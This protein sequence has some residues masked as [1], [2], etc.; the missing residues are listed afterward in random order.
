MNQPVNARNVQSNPQ[1]TRDNLLRAWQSS[2]NALEA[3]KEKEIE[4]RKQVQTLLFP[5]PKKGT[6]RYELGNGYSVKYVHKLN[7]KLGDK[8]KIDD[9]GNKVAINDQVED[10]MVAIEKCGNEGPFLVDRLV[11]TSY[12]LSL[13]EYNQLDPQSPIKKLIDSILIT[14][15]A[16]PEISIEGPK[17]K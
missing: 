8:N 9:D 2:K 11:K 4:L 14:S 15:D 6:Q 10:V 17:R 7:Y 12:D 1:T 16:A 13:S 3:A 5:N